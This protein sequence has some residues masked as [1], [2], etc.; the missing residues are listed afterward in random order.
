MNLTI[1]LWADKGGVGKSTLATSLAAELGATLVDIDPQ[2]DAARWAAL[3][4]MK[5]EVPVNR[6]T[7]KALLASPGLRVVDCPPGQGLEAMIAV[8]MSDLLIIPTRTGEADMVALG[9]SLK[10]ARRI[11][12]D[13]KVGLV[14]NLCRE[15]GRAKGI[16]AALR[17]QTGTHYLWLG[18]LCA[19]VGA[20]ETYAAGRTLL[21]AGGA[22]A[23]EFRQILEATRGLVGATTNH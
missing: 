9:R 8:E 2:G 20:E 21:Q 3:R 13:G 14:L 7:L 12:P 19:R 16:E 18:R 22:V 4:G 5:A 6:K 1:T 15:T 17:A 10:V 23:Y 11:R